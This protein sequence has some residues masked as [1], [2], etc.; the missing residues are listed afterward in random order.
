MTRSTVNWHSLLLIAGLAMLVLVVAE[1]AHAQDAAAAVQT[2]LLSVGSSVAR[3][4]RNVIWAGAIIAALFTFGMFL[5][6]KIEVKRMILIGLAC[7]LVG[8]VGSLVTVFAGGTTGQGQ[9]LAGFDTSDTV[10]D[11]SFTKT[12]N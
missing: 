4:V 2:R 3:V 12:G 7:V 6:G 10:D 11:S 5:A 1:P 9:N 8:V